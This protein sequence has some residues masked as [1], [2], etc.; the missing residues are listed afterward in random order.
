MMRFMIKSDQLIYWSDYYENTDN[1][2][3]KTQT[4]RIVKKATQFSSHFE[5]IF[6]RALQTLWKAWV[7]MHEKS[8]TWTEILSFYQPN[9]SKTTY[10]LYSPGTGKSS[11][12][13]PGQLSNSSR[14]SGRNLPDQ[15]RAYSTQR[16]ISVATDGHSDDSKRRHLSRHISG[17]DFC[18]KYAAE[19][20]A[21]GSKSTNG[22]G[23]RFK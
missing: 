14:D 6:D 15:P 23:G 19:P 22:R 17:R 2:L 3:F 1:T 4:Q 7:Q 18:G 13:I 10:G 12:R 16:K 8:R 20:I 21:I 11:C 9:R 5:R